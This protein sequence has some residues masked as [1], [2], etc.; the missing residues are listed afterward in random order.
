MYE[1]N[2]NGWMVLL[3]FA[4]Q[5]FWNA[6]ANNKEKRYGELEIAKEK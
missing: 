4:L 3:A 2:D 6:F 5:N 1:N